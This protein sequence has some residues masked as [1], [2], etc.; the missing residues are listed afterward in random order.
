MTP[1][2]QGF[3]STVW[4][5]VQPSQ[6]SCSRK[7]S[8]YKFD[9]TRGMGTPKNPP[10]TSISRWS[11]QPPVRRT[12]ICQPLSIKHNLQD[13][14]KFIWPVKWL[15]LKL[16][17]ATPWR[18]FLPSCSKC[19]SSLFLSLCRWVRILL[20]LQLVESAGAKGGRIWRGK[21]TPSQL[22]LLEVL[23]ICVFTT[24]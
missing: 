23:Y 21:D 13:F 2:C 1:D 18:D 5:Q 16:A 10:L 19:F 12:S 17:K 4:L 8:S 7:L 3:L 11:R 24:C 6:S 9:R 20:R 15:K 14:T 22:L